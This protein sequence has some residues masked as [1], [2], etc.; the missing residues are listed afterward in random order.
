MFRVSITL[1]SGVNYIN[2]EPVED[3]M[4]GTL[5]DIIRDGGII[6][7]APNKNTIVIFNASEVSTLTAVKLDG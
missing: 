7:I 3:E 2:Y 1:K 5:Y 4:V 6:K